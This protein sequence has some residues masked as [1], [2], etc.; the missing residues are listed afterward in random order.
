M[1]LPSSTDACVDGFG[2]V[3]GTQWFHGTW[4][5]EQ[6]RLAQD[7]SIARDSMPQGAPCNCGSSVDL[8]CALNEK[9]R[10]LFHRLY[11]SGPG[12]S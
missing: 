6:D 1:N 12:V 2:A 8:G 3:C 10:H 4:T 11:A 7:D 5:A 9:A